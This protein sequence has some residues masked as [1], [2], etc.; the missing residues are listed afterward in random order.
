MSPKMSC[1]FQK[2]TTDLQS[3]QEIYFLIKTTNR[4]KE[5]SLVILV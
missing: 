1:Y 3:H 4:E 2:Q 5:E